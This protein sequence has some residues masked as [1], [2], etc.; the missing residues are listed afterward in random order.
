MP[1]KVLFI[2]CDEGAELSDTGVEPENLFGTVLK[3][4]L[5][6]HIF[7]DRV[8]FPKLSSDNGLAVD[9]KIAG[10]RHMLAKC[11]PEGKRAMLIV[12]KK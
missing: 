5:P 12:K 10:V 8:E 1:N 9:S 3:L 11:L 2:Q 7:K 6:E 4:K